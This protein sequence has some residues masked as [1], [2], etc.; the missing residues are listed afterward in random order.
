MLSLKS[1]F[2]AAALVASVAAQGRTIQILAVQDLSLPD[3]FVFK[4]KD[5]RANVG[6]V[7]EFHFAPTGFLPS[8]HS[9]AQGSFEKAC[10]P[11]PSGFWSGF[12]PGPPGTPLGEAVCRFSRWFALLRRRAMNWVRRSAKSRKGERRQAKAGR[13]R[14]ARGRIC[15]A[16]ISP[17]NR[18]K[19]S[20]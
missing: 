13:K 12:V 9:V 16:D 7:L 3:T 1:L 11:M 5:I 19:Y 18:T 2:T 10:E 17:T 14:G 6:D 20:R 15:G 4:P 8:N